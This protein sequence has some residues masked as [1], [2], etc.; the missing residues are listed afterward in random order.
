AAKAFLER[1]GKSSQFFILE[2]FKR[3]EKAKALGVDS[4][5]TGAKQTF[6]STELVDSD[7]NKK[8]EEERV[9][10]I[11]KIKREHIE[12]LVGT[13]KGKEIIELEDLEDEMVV[14]K[15]P[16][17]GPSHQTLKPVVLVSSMPKPISK[18]IVALASPIAG[19]S[20][21]CIVLSSALKPAATAPISKPAPVK[22]AVRQFKLAGTEESGALIINQVT[23]VTVTQEMLQD[24]DTSDEDENNEDGNDNKGGKSDNDNSDD[25]NNAA[26]DIDSSRH[27]EETQP[28]APT[29]AM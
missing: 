17:A 14:P 29:K 4:E 25:E 2:G 8:E 21:A 18:P 3:K 1:Q 16:T 24:E 28:T 12:E 23:E 7:S 26:M 11:K 19:P 13:R 10:V 20:T 6:K 5:L 15:T 22:S 9:H 27:P